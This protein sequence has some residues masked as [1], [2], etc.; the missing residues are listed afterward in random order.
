MPNKKITL[1]NLPANV[2]RDLMLDGDQ[3]A[4]NLRFIG[5][6]SQVVFAI[7][8]NGAVNTVEYEV[9]SGGRRVVE[10]SQ[11]EAGGTAGVMPALSDKAEAF[12]SAAGEI[13]EFKIR[14]TGGVATS[15]VNMVISVEPV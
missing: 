11:A 1:T 12:Y 14:E 7:N 5:E 13:L 15:D 4:S 9:Y 10:R 2:V 6:P 8:H 3:G